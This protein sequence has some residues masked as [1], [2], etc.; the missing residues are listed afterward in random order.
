MMS[1]IFATEKYKASTKFDPLLRMANGEEST[2]RT[3]KNN[4]ARLGYDSENKVWVG[5]AVMAMVMADSVK[6]S[7]ALLGYGSNVVYKEAVTYPSFFAG[8]ANVLGLMMFGMGVACPPA[9]YLLKRFILPKPGQGP[10]ED[11]LSK[12]FLKVV[13]QGRGTKGTMVTV[14][15]YFPNDPGYVDTSRMAVESG[16]ALAVL[17]K[18]GRPAP[19]PKGGVFT[20][21]PGIG[22]YLVERLT[23]TGSTFKVQMA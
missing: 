21:A 3:K 5:P 9:L 16:I 23:A 18:T 12:G 2:H 15:M 4:Q 8:L 22:S 1:V 20:P 13:G 17:A 11:S 7:N 19:T 14:E 10:S 6:R